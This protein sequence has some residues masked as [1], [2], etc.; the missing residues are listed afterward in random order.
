MGNLLGRT[1]DKAKAQSTCKIENEPMKQEKK[2]KTLTINA[3]LAQSAEA[4]DEE[5][6]NHRYDINQFDCLNVVVDYVNQTGT[7]LEHLRV[8]L[9]HGADP[10]ARGRGGYTPLKCALDRENVRLDLVQLL[11]DFGADPRLWIDKTRGLT[12]IR[13]AWGWLRN[14]NDALDQSQVAKWALCV[15]ALEQAA[16]FL[17]QGPPG[18][19]PPAP[20]APAPPILHGLPVSSSFASSSSSAATDTVIVCDDI[21][22]SSLQN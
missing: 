15:A 6:T 3:W 16:R 12:A 20:P 19:A 1:K 22:Y 13:Y 9:Q 2:K 10:N 14:P 4:L 17:S 8:L 21:D 11:L 5:L 18:P 7:R